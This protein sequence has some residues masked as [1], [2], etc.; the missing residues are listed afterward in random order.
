MGFLGESR[1]PDA[2][3]GDVCEECVRLSRA[4]VARGLG[5]NV[6]NTA[7]AV[8]MKKILIAAAIFIFTLEFA[9]VA[10]IPAFI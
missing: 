8:R 1:F 2:S 6:G 10:G 9:C 4:P 7:A 5:P 3:S